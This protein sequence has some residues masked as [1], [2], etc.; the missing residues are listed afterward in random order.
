MEDGGG[1]L[2]GG[3]D[4]LLI[5]SI[6]EEGGFGWSGSFVEGSEDGE[7]TSLSSGEDD[8]S[9]CWRRRSG[10]LEGGLSERRS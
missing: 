6:V 7:S 10:G 8:G 5:C 3:S 2:G 4:W 9:R 1:E